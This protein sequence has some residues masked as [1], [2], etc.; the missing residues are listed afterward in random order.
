MNNPINLNFNADD[1][2]LIDGI[3]KCIRSIKYN[4]PKL[5]TESEI[6]SKLYEINPNLQN[7]PKFKD[8]V[9]FI[10]FV[11]EHNEKFSIDSFKEIV[12]NYKKEYPNFT[13]QELKTLIIKNND[14]LMDDKVFDLTFN[15]I[16]N[17]SKN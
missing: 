6:L 1:A 7:I 3:T 14:Y 17:S 13:S 8:Y 11:N 2:I 15:A 5:K 12:S 16:Y 10:F 9:N 4:N